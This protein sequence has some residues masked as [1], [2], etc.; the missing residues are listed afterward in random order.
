[1]TCIAYVILSRWLFYLD[2]RNLFTD[3]PD[4]N[5]KKV[6]WSTIYDDEE[7]IFLHNCMKFFIGATKSCQLKVK[8]DT[9]NF[10]H[11]Y[12]KY[13]VIDLEYLCFVSVICVL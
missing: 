11:F 7:Q 13:E 9:V 2:I 10:N 3:S 5:D 1:M 12:L 8:N 6:L 4:R